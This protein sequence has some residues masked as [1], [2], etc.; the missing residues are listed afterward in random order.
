MTGMKHFIY[1]AL[2]MLAL[3]GAL[4]GLWLV[5]RHPPAAVDGE[6]PAGPRILYYVDPMN[7]QHTSDRP[8]PAPCGMP[9]EPVY[10]DHETA[11]G[12]GSETAFP[13]GTTRI[14]SARQQLIGVRVEAV[15]TMAYQ[16]GLRTL[17]RVAADENRTYRITAGANG[18]V[19]N[20]HASTTGSRVEKDQLMATVYNFQFLTRQQQYLYALEFDERK[21][22][23]AAAP[24]NTAPHHQADAAQPRVSMPGQQRVQSDHTTPLS[25]V[26]MVP[27]TVG[28]LNPSAGAVFTIRDQMEVARLELYS[29]G[30]TD[31]QIDAISR[32]R[33]VVPDIEVRSPVAG[34]V[35][36][37]NVSAQ[38]RFDQGDVLFRVADLSRVWIVADVFEPEAQ[39]IRPGMRARVSLP[40]RTEVYEAEVTEVPPEFNT[41][42]R[43]LQ[44]RLEVDNPD[45]TLRP[46]MFVDVE[47]LIP[48][49]PATTLPVDAVLDSGL[50]TTVFVDRGN[51]IFEPRTVET[52][53]RFG[54]RVEIR[55]GLMPGE[56]VAVAG[57]F[58]INSESRMKLAV[59]GLQPAGAE[60]PGQDA[61]GEPAFLA[62][63]EQ[64]HALHGETP[65][66]GMPAVIPLVRK[67][68]AAQKFPQD[69]VCRM[70]V[71]EQ[72][73]AAAGLTSDY[74][75]QTYYFCSDYCKKRFEQSAHLFIKKPLQ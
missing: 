25:S 14:T 62:G 10:A 39:Y 44:V 28:E 24:K 63:Q 55:A 48:L 33:R 36:D 70:G 51:G 35:L 75:G 3:V 22:K 49:P 56:R 60:I 17:G 13:P 52:G 61:G 54:D 45:L 23:A 50:Q 12:G 2:V 66:A 34:I 47:F 74:L 4:G 1:G 68:L 38:Q 9:M 31:H 16:H 21:Q 30:V 72:A 27:A 26:S 58:F 7:P 67:A 57:N 59:A 53:W 41:T 42:A 8:G 29:L 69:P 15:Q 19:W 43:A 73:A 18:W 11:A 32:E 6:S 46:G 5:D 37:R 65:D 20:V 64:E 40:R 71:E